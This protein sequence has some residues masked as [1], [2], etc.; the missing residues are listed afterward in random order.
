MKG[1]SALPALQAEARATGHGL[2]AGYQV[3]APWLYRG[4]SAP[5]PVASDGRTPVAV[6]TTRL[7][8]RT[9][10]VLDWVESVFSGVLQGGPAPPPLEGGAY[11]CYGEICV[12]AVNGRTMIFDGVQL[13]D[14][15]SEQLYL[16]QTEA[17]GY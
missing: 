10:R 16:E 12:G 14:V 5:V 2:W 11:R 8:A 7:A 3:V 4:G 9:D 6:S 15:G 17:E 13:S 1:E